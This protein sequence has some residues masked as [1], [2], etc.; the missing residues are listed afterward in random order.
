VPVRKGATKAE[1]VV[2]TEDLIV[3]RTIT[4]GSTQLVVK[5]RDGAPVPSPQA[6]L[7]KLVGSLTFDPLGFSRM[8]PAEQLS[9]LREMLGLDFAPLDERRAT[10]YEQRRELNREVKTLE[11]QLDALPNVPEGTPDEPPET[12]ALL[13]ALSKANHANRENAAHRSMF[14]NLSATGT[15]KRLRVERLTAELAAEQAELDEV[16]SDVEKYAEANEKLEDVDVAPLEAAIANAADVRGNVSTKKSHIA[17]TGVL[18][19]KRRASDAASGAIA[20]IDVQKADMVSAAKMPVAGLSFADDCVMLN[21]LPFSQAS[22][23]EKLRASV[24]IG[25]AANPELRVLLVRDGSLLD[26][27]SLALVGELAAEKD[28]VVWLERV[29]EGDEC[30]VVIEAGRV[31]GAGE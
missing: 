11:A 30:E 2:E 6:L 3:T 9:T 28:G 10:V 8:A 23:A 21:D 14:A 31:K 16:V 26:A 22:D 13:E 1:I 15:A 29:G 20:R 5:P 4:A 7:D 17:L 19:K 25:F 18:G 12:T 24:G 27:K